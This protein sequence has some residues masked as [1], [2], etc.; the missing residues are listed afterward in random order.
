MKT[1][2]ILFASCLFLFSCKKEPI[3]IDV[4]WQ[5]S[6]DDSQAIN[7]SVSDTLEKYNNDV[8]DVINKAQ[9]LSFMANLKAMAKDSVHVK[10]YLREAFKIDSA[11]V[12]KNLLKPIH[13]YLLLERPDRNT[14]M[15]PILDYEMDY[16][17]ELFKKCN[18]Q[19]PERK[20][21]SEENARFLY[22]WSYIRVRDQWFRV[23]QREADWNVQTRIDEENQKIFDQIFTEK[24]FP[25]EKY[26]ETGLQVLLLHAN[27][28]DWTYKW[29]KFYLDTKNADSKTYMFVS[30]FNNRSFV[31]NDPRIREIVIAYEDLYKNSI[32]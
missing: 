7:Y 25:Q 10:E 27:N 23:P 8:D 15:S 20:Q 31:S 19:I 32:Q 4:P 5:I 1:S 3:A 11:G 26:F 14:S 17:I 24:N 2:Y 9:F 30:H 21:V 22:W 12:C 28:A 13:K 18:F 29:L 6:L 16:V